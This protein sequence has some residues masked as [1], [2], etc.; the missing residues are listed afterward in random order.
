MDI[1][2]WL[3]AKEQ[4]N[5][6]NLIRFI[7]YIKEKK[8]LIFNSYQELYEWSIDDRADFWDVFSKFSN[9]IFSQKHRVV[10]ENPDDM[11]NSKWFSGSQL[12]F[13]ENLLRYRDDH[14]ALIFKSEKIGSDPITLSYQDLYLEVARL[15]KSLCE[16]GISV[17][18]RVV[19][20]MPNLIETVVAMLATTSLG[21]IW[22]T[23]S[24]DFGTQ[25]AIDRFRQ[26][27]PK[28]LFVADGF[29]YMGKSIDSIQ[30]LSPILKELSS[31]EKVV[32]VPYICASP[33]IKSIPNSVMY[34]EFLSK[35]E[36]LS[37][38]FKQVPFD[39]PIVILYSSGTT[40]VPK[41]LVHGGGG[42]LL[43]H[44]KELIL[45]INLKRKDKIFY[46]T[47][48]GW[49]MWNWLISSLAVGATILLFDGSPYYP[50]PDALFNLSQD[51]DITVFGTSARYLQSIEKL[52]LQPKEKFDLSQLRMILSTGSPLLAESFEFVYNHIKENVQVSSISG[53]SDIISCFALNNPLGAVWPGELQCWGLGMSCKVFDEKGNSLTGK[54]GELVCTKSFPSQPVFFWDDNNKKKYKET[55]FNVYPNVWY[56]GDYAEIT[57][58]G[59]IIIYGRSDATLNPY[60]VRIGTAEIYR[61]VEHIPEI[62]DSLV[63]AQ[64]WKGDTRI[65]LFIKL[66]LNANFNK[67]LVNVIKKNIKTNCT[68]NHIPSKIIPIKEIPY[69][70]SGKKVELVVKK[71]IEGEPILNRDS[72]KNPE[73]L[74]LYKNLPELQR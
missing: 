26:I 50:T 32:V 70:L 44:M 42:T 65:V 45:H 38:K 41:C 33:D 25:G 55:Y 18:D 22:S 5:N 59:G 46:F 69:T 62:T 52:G 12:N 39:H 74:D 47:T 58:H 10:L 73:V 63:I 14:P 23:C 66:A 1:S 67:D 57:K 13:A 60:G 20:F 61:Q 2:P 30:K 37:V 29:F 72:L 19:G 43:Q 28:V 7:E 15:A 71:I 21:A 8:G 68:P 53:G 11:L 35:E 9:I 34:Q 27:K 64:K 24:P 49:M 4:L 36:N 6:I 51:Q 48:C 54:K 17:G 31:V 40:G 16:M 56:H 3:P